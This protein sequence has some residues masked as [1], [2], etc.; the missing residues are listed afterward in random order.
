MS[1]N[2][3]FY[4]FYRSLFLTTILPYL[5]YA[6]LDFSFPDNIAGKNMTGWAWIIMFLITL[7]CFFEGRVDRRYP[8]VF[9]MP[10]VLYLVLYL[11]NDFSVPGLQLTIQLSLPVFIGYVASGYTYSKDELHWLFKKMLQVSFFVVFLFYY[12]M[13]FRGGWTPH[14]AANPM[15][16]S[17]MA[18][19][20]I[21]FFYLSKKI[22]YM[23]IYLLLFSVPFVG[24]TRMGILVFVVIFMFHFV[25]RSISSKIIPISLGVLLAV[26][27][28]YSEGFQ[29][30][31]FYDGSGDITDISFNYYEATG[32]M[33][34]SG[35]VGFLKYYEYGLKEAPFWG[36]GPRADRFIR[37]GYGLNDDAVEV[38]NDYISVRY[39]YGY[40]GLSLLMFG[41][42]CTFISLYRKYAKEKN[43]Y[44][45]LIYSTSLTLFFAFL[46][47]MYT[48]NIL[49][50][51]IFFPNYF[52]ALIGM[53]F[54]LYEE[55][56]I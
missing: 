40:I 38:C 26:F 8:L 5:P 50:Y 30:K 7:F 16:L 36:H 43:G 19:I 51:T 41:F 23:L 21:G 11:I 52:F 32:D 28:F 35:R 48:D 34:T 9:W 49:K 13:L 24:V 46:L 27:V 33:N 25:N 37:M 17:V 55:S 14:G 6:L 53:A 10:W 45:L 15:I 4:L 44:K 1:Q 20:S 3:T 18:A 2:K 31:M 56:D 54:K 22:V 29:E 12:G 42:F 47:F 39:N